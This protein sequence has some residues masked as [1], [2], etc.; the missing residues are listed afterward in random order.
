[1]RRA[2]S[3]VLTTLLLLPSAWAVGQER[4]TDVS[5]NGV[6]G[7]DAFL[8]S[9]CADGSTI[10]FRSDADFLSEGRGDND[11]EIWLWTSS[12]LQRL[13]DAGAN[14]ATGRDAD[15]P[16]ISD[17]GDRVAFRS[18]A[19]Y[20]SE[21]RTRID[22][23]L[24]RK[25]VGLS[26]L[27]DVTAN[28]ASSRDA[29]NPSISGDGTRIAFTSDADFLADGHADND[30]D[31]WLWREVG[32]LQQL[33]DVSLYGTGSRRVNDVSLNADGTRAAFW[34]DGDFLDEGRAD[35]DFD[36]WLWDSASGLSRLTDVTAGSATGRDVANCTPIIS[37]DGTR[38]VF[39]SDADFLSEGRADNDFEIW[40]W[41]QASGLTRITD[42]TANGGSNRDAYNAGISGDG[43]TIVFRS[44]ADLLNDGIADDQFETY[45]YDIA[46]A[47]LT[48]IS[49]SS[50][51][52]NR[53]TWNPVVSRSGE[54]VAFSSDSEMNG[55][56]IAAGDNELWAWPAAVL[57]TDGFESSSAARWSSAAGS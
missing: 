19:D 4:L 17:D 56:T 15:Q 39:C 53:S 25:G 10:A 40:L 1:M 54:V 21:G 52:A 8:P 29:T 45:V 28:M 38:I 44:D 55:Q 12:G 48:R 22:V 49:Q 33:T 16:T 3:C 6:S 5:T 34:S 18:N 32:G 50:D 27:T 30:W 36:L 31:L 23:W 47:Q 24:W 51:G 43:T 46:A 2:S 7:R 41:D 20:L 9:I 35:D 57:F 37:D 13:T 11:L 26:R 42:T 14:S